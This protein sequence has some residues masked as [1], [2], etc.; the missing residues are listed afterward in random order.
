MRQ[1]IYQITSIR[2]T[3]T[4]FHIHCVACYTLE[5]LAFAL[6][7]YPYEF[8]VVCLPNRFGGMKPTANVKIVDMWQW[9]H[10]QWKPTRSYNTQYCQSEFHMN[11]FTCNN[12]AVLAAVNALHAVCIPLLWWGFGRP[13]S[14]APKSYYEVRHRERNR[15]KLRNGAPFNKSILFTLSLNQYTRCYCQLNF[16]DVGS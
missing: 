7:S 1:F 16:V 15:V 2:S 8:S 10:L 9:H 4:E 12:I 3:N 14:S 13:R 5:S 11:V 6:N